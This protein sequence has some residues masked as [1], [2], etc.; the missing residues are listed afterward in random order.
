MA[1]YYD[2]A[3]CVVHHIVADRTHDGATQ[4]T[5]APGSHDD[6]IALLGIGSVTDHLTWLLVI[7]HKLTI[8]LSKKSMPQLTGPCIVDC[9]L[10]KSFSSNWTNLTKVLSIIRKSLYIK[11][12]LDYIRNIPNEEGAKP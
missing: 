10:S 1:R 2:G 3:V 6:V 4:F 11:N 12:N 8:N 7:C 5:E 9:F